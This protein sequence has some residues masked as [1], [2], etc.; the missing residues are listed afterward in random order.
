[1]RTNSRGFWWLLLT[2]GA[3]L[4]LA[5]GAACGGGDDDDDDDDGGPTASADAGDDEEETPDEG[6]DDEETDEPTDE[7]SGDDDEDSELQDALDSISEEIEDIQGRVTYEM[8]SGGEVTTMTYYADGNRSRIDFSSA[9]GSTIFITTPEASY[10]CFSDD[11][12]GGQCLEA[13]GSEDPA[14]GLLPFIGQYTD[15]EALADLVDTFGGGDV[16][17]S[18]EEIAGIDASCFTY[19]GAIFED[20]GTG[21]YCFAEENGLLLLVEFEGDVESD[22]YRMEAT[23]A[24]GEVS[25]SDFEPPYEI[26]DFGDIGQ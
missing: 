24:S 19:S 9:D 14:E 22:N 11:A 5:L 16:D 12:G 25:D 21:K 26:L 13:E 8:T 4:A 3:A 6:D 20:T 2:L 1:M 10:S 17:Y 18:S 7:P 23:D 15:P